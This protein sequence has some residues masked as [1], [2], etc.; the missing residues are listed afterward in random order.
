MYS[1]GEISNITGLTKRSLRFYETKG[2]LM[3]E[4]KQH[5]RYRVYSEEDLDKLLKIQFFKK[6]GFSLIETK[7]ILQV[8]DK[9]DKI[10]E[11][12][13][14]LKNKREVCLKEL[15]EL[16]NREKTIGK[17]LEILKDCRKISPENLEK[18]TLL[19]KRERNDIMETLSKIT[20]NLTG[21][22]NH[23]YFYETL[24]EELKKAE[25]KSQPLSIILSDLDF[26]K[27]AN[28]EFG[29]P[30]GDII[31]KD[32]GDIF[33]S[34]MGEKD[35]SYRYGGDEFAVI[36]V[37]TKKEKAVELA[38]KIRAAIE[39]YNF[40]IDNK[41]VK[42]TISMGVASI[43]DDGK[44]RNDLMKAADTAAHRVKM[45]GGNQVKHSISSP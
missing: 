3:P 19:K 16:M 41:K 21:L 26:F 13:F 20:D 25:E 9:K 14:A 15:K 32:T 7:K 23:R 2:L 42:I 33:K 22:F 34:F 30:K 5:N 1:I 36:C 29:H 37:N 27:K 4:K 6:L 43:P 45:T 35:T 44:N 24:G 8:L 10:S 40:T 28:D 39:K 31:L 38:E 17:T 18:L 12:E 11:V